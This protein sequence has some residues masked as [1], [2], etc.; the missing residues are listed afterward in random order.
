LSQ[1][2]SGSRILCVPFIKDAPSIGDSKE[3]TRLAANLSLCAA[4]INNAFL[5]YLLSLGRKI[6]RHK[7]LEFISEGTGEDFLSA[8]L[9]PGAISPAWLSVRPLYEA[10]I[11]VL[12]L[13]GQPPFVGL[14]LNMRSTRL[15]NQSCHA[16]LQDKM[17]LTGL[18]VG[19]LEPGDDSRLAPYFKL[20]GRVKAIDGDQL[21][22]DDSRDG[23]E[24]IT[25]REAYLE[26]NYH[27][28][29]RCIDHVFKDQFVNVKQN[30][31]N[32]LS[33]FRSGPDRLAKLQKVTEY[34]AKQSLEMLPDV[35]F[36]IG[37]LMSSK[38]SDFF[39][40]IL[41]AP[42]TVYVFDP[43]GTRTDTWHDRGLDNNGP[44]TS[45][46]FTPTHP[47][48]CII[49]Q[50]DRKGRVEQFL[51][52]FINGIKLSGE[53]RS[54]FLKGFIR[55]YSLENL[56]ADFFLCENNSADAYHQAARQAIAQHGQSNV[57][58]D[59]ALIQI[60]ESFHN[61]YGAQ[62]P[63]LVTKADFLSH[64]I[65]VQEFE[66][67]TINV[68]DS[69]LSYV[70]NNIALASYAKIGGI[71]WLIKANPTIAHELV[72]GLGSAFIGEGR[73]NKK[74]RVVG[75]TT[76][77][78]G[79][80]NYWLSNLS[81]AVPID[82]YEDAL[83]SS[84]KVTVNRVKADMNWQKRE[85]VRLIFHSF[86]PLKFAE[87]DAV[88]ALMDEL[89]DFDVEYAFVHVIENHP[90]MLFDEEQ[91]GSK[92]F[93]TRTLK[94]VFAPTRGL[95]LRLSDNE[96]LISL[97][98]AREVKR[99]QD[100]LPRPILLRLHKNSTFHDTTYLARQ[101]YAFSSHSWRSFFPSPMPVTILYSELIAKMLGQL[102][103][104]PR[105]NPDAM[106]GKIGRTRWFL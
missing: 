52:K 2:R 3:S 64:Q 38:K 40:P 62:N 67:E 45:Q 88:K 75:I 53:K 74:E 63:Y 101:V 86:K 11:R 59:L 100:G 56:T 26:P 97:T 8:S 73:S 85:H 66:F 49:C 14:A 31:V 96:V 55:K 48:V 10:N 6:L 98:G 79:D 58:W 21:L 65:P 68:P 25:A 71:P 84:L 35:K 105:W 87:V 60:D 50:K 30:L 32:K 33:A 82:N 78:S 15:I 37:S 34:L 29:D 44:Y 93:E 13:D 36:T 51:H 41:T 22:L 46:S 102:A 27:E 4:L 57:K 70:L 77:F 90:F 104:L 28:F 47:R 7:P 54:P 24:S 89:G 20:R 99:P 19:R 42:K 61:L 5:V 83:L 1:N 72:V 81:E 18:Y 95:F 94:G 23:V 103:L 12:A 106:L 69:Q 76:V 17:P 39:P 43:A 91:T 92:D 16:L 80:G 9:S